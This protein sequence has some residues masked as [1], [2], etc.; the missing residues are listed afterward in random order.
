LQRG[1]PYQSRPRSD[2][3]IRRAARVVPGR[4]LP[5][6]TSPGKHHIGSST[7]TLP[8]RLHV[9]EPETIEPR[10]VST[11]AAAGKDDRP[12]TEARFDYALAKTWLDL[13]RPESE[14]LR[15]LP[16]GSLAVE[17]VR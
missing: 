13:T 8:Y 7:A 1:D 6:K 17:Q 4:R 5:R 9:P 3:P 16:A 14:L 11:S 10:F 2:L 12:M 15:P